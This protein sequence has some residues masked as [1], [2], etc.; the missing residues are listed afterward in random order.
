MRG[1][2]VLSLTSVKRAY[3]LSL[4]L[5][6]SLWQVLRALAVSFS[7]KRKEIGLCNIITIILL[8]FIYLI[9]AQEAIT[10]GR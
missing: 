3:S 8:F 7:P 9:D 10:R 5:S 6:L 1:D 4:S 2:V